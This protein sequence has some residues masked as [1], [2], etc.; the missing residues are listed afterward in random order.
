MFLFSFV[1][2]TQLIERWQ[3]FQLSN[4][5]TSTYTFSSYS[6]ACVAGGIRA[7]ERRRSRH[8][9]P[10][11]NFASGEAALSRL[12]HSRSRL[13]LPKQKHSRAK[14]HQLRRLHVALCISIHVKLNLVPRISHLPSSSTLGGW[15]DEGPWEQGC[16]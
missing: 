3:Q 5:V 6:I 1:L 8:I 14:S 7:G 11:R 16:S 15:E 10:A 2:K 9:Q 13:L 12:Y 4:V